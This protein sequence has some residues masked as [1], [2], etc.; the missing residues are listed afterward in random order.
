MS[1]RQALVSIVLPTYN[2][3]RFLR[4]S[5][6]SCLAQTHAALELII[7][8]GGSTDRT[9][10]IVSSYTDPRVKLIHQP[11][12]SGKLPGALT[13][14]LQNAHGEYLTWMQADCWY[15]PRAIELLV[16]YL[17]KHADVDLVYAP[18]A[19]VDEDGQPLGDGYTAPVDD[20][21]DHNCVGMY[22]LWRRRV[23]EAVG[24]FDV[25]TYLAEDYEYWLR[26]AQ[27]FK[28]AYFTDLPEPMYY[29]RF[30]RDALTFMG[31]TMYRRNRIA[32]QF[33]RQ[34]FGL[35]RAKYRKEMGWAHLNEAF[36]RH[37]HGERFSVTRHVAA[38][39]YYDPSYLRNLGAISIGLEGLIGPGLMAKLRALSKRLR[40]GVQPSTTSR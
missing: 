5:M 15:Q 14:G 26:I 11:A 21:I 30:H 31:Y 9:L 39:F 24:G 33:K 4:E 17:D 10:A 19:N 25:N 27:R 1:E 37:Q 36:A 35:S 23:T 3:E 7:V 16:Q 8:D 29:Y 2:A 40:G 13:L 38:G 6:D 22:H 32:A 18:Y 34:K 28:L 20:L 12:N